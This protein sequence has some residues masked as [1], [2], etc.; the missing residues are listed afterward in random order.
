MHAQ[1]RIAA[2]TNGNS[3]SV[4]PASGALGF[5]SPGEPI[6]EGDLDH[7][8]YEG[9]KSWRY[10]YKIPKASRVGF[11]WGCRLPKISMA[12]QTPI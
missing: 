8:W 10:D 1:D 5:R 3:I 2:L 4:M 6:I 7:Q 9:Q 12:F 11:L